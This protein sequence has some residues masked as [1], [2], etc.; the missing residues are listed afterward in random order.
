[1]R[2][3][4]NIQI[5]ILI[6]LAVGTVYGQ[7]PMLLSGYIQTDNRIR[8]ESSKYTWNENRLNLRLEGAGSAKYHY[9]SEIRL[10]GFGFPSVTSTSDLQL[11]EK[12]KVYG[13]GLEF[14][15][16]Y[17]DLYQF[18][19]ENLD[20]RIGR[21]II[22]WG[23]ADALN[24]TN[25][26]S[27]DDLEDIYNFGAQLGTNAVNATYY[28]GDASLN[29]AYIPVFTPATLPSGDFAQAFAGQLEV[30]EGLVLRSFEDTII[31][32]ESKMSTSSQYAARFSTSLRGHDI[33]ISYFNGRDDLPLLNK[34]DISPVDAMGTIDITTELVYPE[35]QVIGA[36]YA[37]SIRDIGLWAEGAL[38]IPEKIDLVSTIPTPFGTL[39]DTSVALSDDPYLRFVVGGD[40][41]FKGGFYV[42]TQYMHGFLHERGKDELN[43]YLILRLEKTFMNGRLK[44]APLTTALAISD[45]ED[46]ENNYGFVLAP[47]V[48]Y[49]P[50][51]N[52]EMSLGTF[53]L[54]GKGANLFSN[55]KDNDEVFIKVKVSF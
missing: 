11:R 50:A 4:K 6:C 17:L 21:Q 1:M 46:F 44:V 52:I 12:D 8:T 34:M 49:L 19:L 51:D 13:W 14:R 7:E 28:L 9:F 15:E 27:P 10:R 5:L 31:L 3:F 25:N 33:S 29:V 41:T 18:G 20:L 16:A 55:I 22:K 2:T 53:V 42:N 47:E 39:V 43:D 45:W 23:T 38:F 26:L 32:P 37:G 48:T 54:E 24:P 36:D 35:I 30:P 40:Y